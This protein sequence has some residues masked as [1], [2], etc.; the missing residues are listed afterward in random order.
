MINY[1][2]QDFLNIIKDSNKNFKPYIFKNF[3]NEEYLPSWIDFLNCIYKEWQE[4]TDTE[5]AKEV[6]R[7]KETLQGSVI[8]GADLYVNALGSTNNKYEKFE[9]YFP[10][11]FDIIKII[12]SETKLNIALSGPK[13]CIGPYQ[14][15]SHKDNWAAFSLQ[16][17]GKTKWTF[18]NTS[19]MEI[20]SPI[21]KEV[22]EMVPG[23]FVFFPKGMYHQIEVTA[24]RASIQF[25]TD[26]I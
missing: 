17:Q 21:Y 1:D 24:P 20:E 19:L 10:T 9:Q 23:D 25:N 18:S 6:A 12:N 7:N 26:L 11:I 5:L 22:I 2:L 16:C 15:L 3:I 13:I 8:V 14:N 4:P